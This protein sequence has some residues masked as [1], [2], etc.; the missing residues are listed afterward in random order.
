MPTVWDTLYDFAKGTYDSAADYFNSV[1]SEASDAYA[2]S[3]PD[4]SDEEGS[5]GILSSN[6]LLQAGAKV[7]LKGLA[8]AAGKDKQESLRNLEY[9]TSPYKQSVSNPDWRNFTATKQ[10]ANV[11]VDPNDLTAQWMNKLAVYAGVE[12]STEVSPG[13]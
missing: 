8:A 1:G 3:N 11:S 12:R 4:T 2:K 10:R 5:G 7:G 6:N 13:K 9:L